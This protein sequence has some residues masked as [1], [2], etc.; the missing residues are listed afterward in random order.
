MN[1]V[2]EYP[3]EKI[4]KGKEGIVE[5]PVLLSANVQRTSLDAK[6]LQ[7]LNVCL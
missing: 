2:C 4:W 6:L 3:L 1:I 5:E 7:S